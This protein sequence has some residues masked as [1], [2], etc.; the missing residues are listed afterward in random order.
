MS[1]YAALLL[2]LTL[3]LPLGASAQTPAPPA[4]PAGPFVGRVAFASRAQLAELNARL[5]VWEVHPQEGYLLAALTPQQAADLQARGYAIQVDP[6]RTARLTHPPEESPYQTSGI[7]GYACYRTVEETYTDLG[8]LAAAHPSLAQWVDIGDSWEKTI[9]GGSPG[10][11]I[12]A[13]VLTNRSIPGPKPTFFLM[14]AIHAR[15]LT[16]AETATRFAEYLVNNYGSDPQATWLLDFTEIHIVPQTNP[17]GRKMAETGEYWRKNTDNDDGCTTYP[18]YG[19]DL[20]RNSSYMWGGLGASTNPCDSTY[21]GPSAASEP[22]IQAIQTYVSSI[23]PDQRGSG[24]NDPAPPDATGTFITLHSYSQLVLWPWG[25][26]T[27]QAPNHA[28]LQTLGRKFAY[29]N[30]YTPEQSSSLY[31]AAGTTDDWAY[32]ELGVAAYTFELGNYFFESCAAFE[33]TIYPD[34]LP[35]LLYAA[36][37]SRRPYQ[38]PAGPDTLGLTLTPTDTLPGAPVVIAAQADDT[39]YGV[40]GGV[41]PSQNVTAA[42]YSIDA[43][44]WVSGTLTYPLQPADGAWDSSIEGLAGQFTPSA[45]GLSPGRHTLF[46]EARDA[47]GA[48]GAP[49]AAFFWMPEYGF[50]VSPMQA[51]QYGNPGDTLTYTLHLTNSAALSDTYALS[52]SA[53]SWDA[54]A[55]SAAGP[56]LPGEAVTLPVTV[57]IPA[58]AP[59]GISQTLRLTVASLGNPAER[60]SAAFTAIAADYQP[61]I[62]LRSPARQWGPPGHALTYTLRVRNAGNLAETYL[63]SAVSGAWSVT[64]P[65]DSGAPL[66][67]EKARTL[68]AVVH[69]PPDAAP[70]AGD[71]ITVTAVSQANPLQRA[72]LVLQAGVPR[73]GW[74]AALRPAGGSAPSGAPLTYTLRLTNTG[75]LT[76]TYALSAA[77][78]PWPLTLPPAAPLPAGAAVRAPLTVTVPLSAAAGAGYTFTLEVRSLGD[79]SQA[80]TLTARAE[81]APSY[82]MEI[83]LLPP[84]A[85][86][87]PGATLSAT[88]RLTNTGNLSDTFTFQIGGAWALDA[89]PPAA[90]SAWESVDLPLRLRVP[91][92][93]ADGSPADLHVQVFSGSPQAPPVSVSLDAYAVW[94]RL[95]LPVLRR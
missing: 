80:L 67:P 53:P 88:L 9:P 51:V 20:N 15:E 6:A 48:W 87:Y 28:Q 69:I 32:G 75:S 59:Y 30:G 90:L 84:N 50:S 38:T 25:F 26:D 42:R 39:R 60:L 95:Y 71:T 49:A 36:S 11:D 34:N 29:F 74:Q 66:P 24:V 78:L 3:L 52:L 16:T 63:L 44:S 10:Y 76:D 55:P 57:S 92:D 79:P 82:G 54:G 33:N 18:S 17:D 23:F 62:S 47:S 61:R 5:D 91:A 37:A 21:R 94:R 81:A 1:R 40:L 77:G 12:Y 8:A 43:P 85:P 22:E 65:G 2:L 72:S 89:L 13:L 86:A 35:A 46:V 73:Y 4:L 27:P 68:R 7:P 83:A 64:L 45:L 14:A 19:T 70:G 58:A 56:L 31:P 41:E 93:S